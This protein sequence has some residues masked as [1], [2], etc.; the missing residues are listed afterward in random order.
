MTLW[1]VA[2]L[3]VCR[4]LREDYWENSIERRVKMR[5]LPS[6]RVMSHSYANCFLPVL[7]SY[8]S[9]IDFSEWKFVRRHTQLFQHQTTIWMLKIHIICMKTTHYDNCIFFLH[10]H[11]R[12]RTRSIELVS[13]FQNLLYFHLPNVFLSDPVVYY[14]HYLS[15]SLLLCMS[16]N[17]FCSYSF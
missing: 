12:R 13:R 11:Q 5:T 16:F 17:P 4:V 10:F 2:F 8:S 14:C 9:L 15:L 1:K 3:D 6:L 7:P